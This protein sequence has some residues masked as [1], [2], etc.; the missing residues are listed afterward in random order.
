LWLKRKTCPLD[1]DYNKK[2]SLTSTTIVAIT[3]QN[4]VAHKTKYIQVMTMLANV[5]IPST[6][7]TMST[8]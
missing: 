7:T 1:I 4:I 5:W 6:K 3:S 8:N 2:P